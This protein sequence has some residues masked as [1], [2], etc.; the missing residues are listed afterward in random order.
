[1]TEILG[2]LFV[3]L[4]AGALLVWFLGAAQWERL[5]ELSDL[6]QKAS[7]FRSAPT[8]LLA[9]ARPRGRAAHHAR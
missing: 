5:A 4:A 6:L 2:S 3:G 7:A 8:R 9:R 1:M